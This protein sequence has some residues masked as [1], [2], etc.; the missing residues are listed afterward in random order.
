[1]HIHR[2]IIAA[3]LLGV[4]PLAAY[5][6]AP[7]GSPEALVARHLAASAKGDVEGI[8][9]DYSDDAVTIA[10]PSLRQAAVMTAAPWPA[11]TA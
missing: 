2:P 10:C 9:A 8:V 7:E 3:L 1:M 11:S 4:T 5:S 6:A